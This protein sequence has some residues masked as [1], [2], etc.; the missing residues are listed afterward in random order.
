[1]KIFRKVDLEWD[2]FSYWK[3]A[4]LSKVSVRTSEYDK[5]GCCAYQN[6][7]LDEE[8]RKIIASMESWIDRN[9]K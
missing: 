2:Y 7:E 6:L 4:D 5:N 8:G 1:M 9:L 3:E